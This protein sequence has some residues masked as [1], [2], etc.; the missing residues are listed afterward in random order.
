MIFPQIKYCNGA[1][2]K[3]YDQFRYAFK[4]IFNDIWFL[5]A[6]V[7]SNKIFSRWSIAVSWRVWLFGISPRQ[8]ISFKIYENNEFINSAVFGINIKA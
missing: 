3:F 6:S 8:P 2:I 5:V 1:P 4:K 7:L